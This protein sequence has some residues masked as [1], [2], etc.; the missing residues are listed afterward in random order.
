MVIDFRVRPPYRGFL[1]MGIFTKYV[2]PQKDPRKLSAFEMGRA[3][4]PSCEQRSMEL[5]M[6][7][8]DEAGV[9]ACVVMGRKNKGHA[10]NAGNILPEDLYELAD[11]HP[12]RFLPF[13]G[14]DP[15]DAG[16]C[17][18]VEYVAKELGFKGISMD[19][20]W[21]EPCMHADDERILAVCETASQLGIIVTLTASGVA[22][23]DLSYADPLTISAW[24]R[25]FRI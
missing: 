21:C 11:S 19:P 4:V 23:P 25:S 8:M 20:G 22:G 5:F 1:E 10:I 7:E 24:P 12:G 15:N 16:A 6:Q 9:E 2:V 18:E 14:I 17:K 13:A 3:G